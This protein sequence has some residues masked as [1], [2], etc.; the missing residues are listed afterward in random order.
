MAVARKN[1]VN[2]GDV[3]PH[4]D[5]FLDVRDFVEDYIENVAK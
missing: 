2:V 4:H 3:S 5:L 1:I